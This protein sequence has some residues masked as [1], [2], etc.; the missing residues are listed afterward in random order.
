MNHLKGAVVM[1]Q[2]YFCRQE[3]CLH[4]LTLK[5]PT[6][7]GR[8][9]LPTKC[10]TTALSPYRWGLAGSILALETLK[11]AMAPINRA[12]DI[13]VGQALQAGLVPVLLAKL[14]WRRERRRYRKSSFPICHAQHLTAHGYQMP[15]CLPQHF[16]L[17]SGHEQVASTERVSDAELLRLMITEGMLTL[18]ST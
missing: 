14:D 11:L 16:L 5:R 9:I 7:L 12:R 3:L 6:P 4:D 10:V 2:V 1:L 8:T 15:D 13:L 18:T 17:C